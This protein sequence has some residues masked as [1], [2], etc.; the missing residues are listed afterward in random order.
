MKNVREPCVKGRKEKPKDMKIYLKGIECQYYAAL[1]DKN[2]KTFE[3]QM[4]IALILI[5]EC[6]TK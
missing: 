2:S 1:Q 3:K 6:S 4:A 5:K